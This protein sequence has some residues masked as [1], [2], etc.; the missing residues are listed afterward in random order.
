MKWANHSDD[1]FVAVLRRLMVDGLELREAEE[2][3]IST[4]REA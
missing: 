2:R 4:Q 1:H 3:G